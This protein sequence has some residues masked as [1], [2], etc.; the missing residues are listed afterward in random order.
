ML[1]ERVEQRACLVVRQRDERQG[2][3]VA[4]PSAPTG[5]ALEELGPGG[6]HHEQRD[7]DDLVD[8][9]ID[10]VEQ[11]VVG[12]VEIVEDE[13]RDVSLGERL[14]EPPPGGHALAGDLVALAAGEADERPQVT[15]DPRPLG[16]IVEER[17]GLPP[18]LLLRLDRRVG[19]QDAGLRLHHL[20]ERPVRDAAAV[21]Q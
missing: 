4:L 8:Q 1:Q 16:G 6:A 11:P 10:E 9:L 5:T 2:L 12:P 13:D 14:E 21:G 18:E 7:A 3:G 15:I 20:A 19:L 17:R